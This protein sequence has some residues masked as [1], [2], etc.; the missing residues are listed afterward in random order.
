M[1]NRI[2]KLFV[3]GALILIC[4]ILLNNSTTTSILSSSTLVSE[5]LANVESEEAN[6]D[7]MVKHL[8]ESMGV[9]TGMDVFNKKKLQLPDASA[10][11][12]LYG[13]GDYQEYYL[14]NIPD[15]YVLSL[16]T[17]NGIKLNIVQNAG[18]DYY[19][20]PVYGHVDVEEGNYTP[21]AIAYDFSCI[22]AK[23][24]EGLYEISIITG[25]EWYSH[26]ST[27]K[28]IGNFDREDF[29]YLLTYVR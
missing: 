27:V 12:I 11:A 8:Q 3:A 9:P 23:N 13:M 5:N 2:Y 4:F 10:V 16:Y 29:V 20:I 14:K 21:I 25:K 17:D 15:I 24:S 28:E 7:S 26:T 19:M 22:L 6:S 1:F 18:D